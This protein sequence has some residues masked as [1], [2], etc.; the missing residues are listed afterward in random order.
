MHTYIEDI[1]KH[2]GKEITIKGWL[3]NK[4]SSGKIRFILLRDGTGVV[5]AVIAKGEVN[6]ETFEAADRITQESSVILKGQVRKDERAPGGYEIVAKE[7]EVLQ[8]AQEYPI[9]PKEHSI[10]YLMPLRHLWLRSRLQNAILRIRHELI[11]ACRDFLDSNG[12]IN[13]DTPI[14]TPASVE[15]TTTLFPV[16]YYGDTVYLAQSGQLYNEA[17][18]GA[19]GREIEDEAPSHRILDAGTRGCIS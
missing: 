17:T 18:I 13:A 7:I 12:F 10:E 9:T 16:D 15:G 8:M 2:E 6:D 5:Q 4:R 14:L 19:L 3:Y 1:G 11:K